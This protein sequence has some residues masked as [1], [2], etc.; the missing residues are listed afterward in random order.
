MYAQVDDEGNEFILL[1]EIT[2]HRSDASAIPITDSTIRSANGS[3]K[4]KKTTQGWFL[5][6]Q[7]K[8][9]SVSWEK[10]SDL[11]AS[12]PVEVA[13]YAV[14]NRL[15]EQPAFKWWV[16]HVIKHRNRI[17]SKVKLQYWKSTGRK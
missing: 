11:K 10:L 14:A 15:V 1:D 6:V 12:N 3:E 8:D 5:L 2:D 17:I 4:P 9:G 7:W 16:P 13:E